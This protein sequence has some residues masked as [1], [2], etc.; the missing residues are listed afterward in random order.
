MKRRY[1]TTLQRAALLA[2]RLHGLSPTA[3]LVG[4]F[5]YI[6]MEETAVQSVKELKKDDVIRITM[7]D[8]TAEARVE[9]V[10]LKTSE[11]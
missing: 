11:E 3:K 5:G 2:E 7:H 4:G 1:E 10:N 9:T 8:G 6:S